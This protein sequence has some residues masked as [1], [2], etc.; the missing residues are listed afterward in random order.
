MC[1]LILKLKD[2]YKMIHVQQQM[3]IICDCSFWAVW[4]LYSNFAY[5][6]WLP[7]HDS[8]TS[9]SS[10]PNLSGG[11][12]VQ[13]YCKFPKKSNFAS[14]CARISSIR[15][16]NS[17]HSHSVNLTSEMQPC[18]R[19]IEFTVQRFMEQQCQIELV[20]SSHPAHKKR[21]QTNVCGFGISS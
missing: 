8:L 5:L 15:C 19:K 21:K 11:L 4:P 10:C 18:G 3:G 9:W 20:Q 13:F 12:Q 7:M 6:A 14:S 16:L 2:I 1:Q 17:L